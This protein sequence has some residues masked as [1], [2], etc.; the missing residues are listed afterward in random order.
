MFVL[1]HIA[2][3]IDL[4]FEFDIYVVVVARKRVCA[5]VQWLNVKPSISALSGAPFEFGFESYK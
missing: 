5:V 3:A 2:V 1:P 4:H